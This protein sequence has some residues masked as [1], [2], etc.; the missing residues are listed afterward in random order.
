MPGPTSVSPRLCA[1]AFKKIKEGLS[2]NALCK[3]IYSSLINSDLGVER[4]LIQQAT[5]TCSAFLQNLI[6]KGILSLCLAGP[7]GG[8]GTAV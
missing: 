7:R 3:F 4:V 8:S 1:Y 6:I 2:S 5:H